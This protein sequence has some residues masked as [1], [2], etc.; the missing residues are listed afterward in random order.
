MSGIRVGERFK[1]FKG[2]QYIV[3][4]FS[5]NVTGDEPVKHVLYMPLNVRLFDGVPCSRSIENF[6][7][8]VNRRVDYGYL[9]PRFT[10]LE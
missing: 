9:G 6:L 1:H 8:V 7:E 4:G 3:T 5:M 10:R 2:D